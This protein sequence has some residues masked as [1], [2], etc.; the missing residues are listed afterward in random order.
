MPLLSTFGAA[1]V[2]GFQGL[3]RPAVAQTIEVILPEI[4]SIIN[5]TIS[6][7]V[8]LSD[9]VSAIESSNIANF[10]VVASPRSG[11]FAE[12]L[13]SQ[14][15]SLTSWGRFLIDEWDNPQTLIPFSSSSGSGSSYPTEGNGYG[16]YYLISLF[17]NDTIGHSNYQGTV[18]I[19]HDDNNRT[20]L[21]SFFNNQAVN[22]SAVVIN[23]QNTSPSSYFSPASFTVSTIFSDGASFGPNGYHGSTAFSNDDGLWGYGTNTGGTLDGNGGTYLNNASQAYGFENRNSG[24][25]GSIGAFWNFDDFDIFSALITVVYA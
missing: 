1:S 10:K 16:A 8:S 17:G 4:N 5:N 18:A 15:G 23:A 14:S 9:Y 12:N 11:A 6:G 3:G 25:S 13:T 2:R 22:I 7:S 20:T 24:D 19:I 21:P